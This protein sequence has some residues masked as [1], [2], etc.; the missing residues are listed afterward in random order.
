M[1]GPLQLIVV[2]FDEDKYARDIIL[3]L[4]SLRKAKTILLFDLLYLFKHEDGTIDA[5]EVSDLQEEEQREFGTLVKS[6]LGLSARDVEHIDAEAVAGTLE[7]ADGSFGLSDSELQ[8]LADQIPNGSSAIFVVFEHAWA[9]PLKAA[10]IRTGG[11]VRAQGIIDPDTLKSA[12]NELAAVLAAV[13]KAEQATMEQMAEIMSGAKSQEEEAQARAAEAMAEADVAESEAATTLEEAARM[14]EEAEQVTAEA[15]AREEA[16]REHAAQVA[17]EAEAMEDEAFAEAEAVRRA[18]ER[19]QEK[20]LAEAATVESRAKEIEAAA[21]MRA[22]NA[23]ISA[24]VIEPAE[25]RDALDAVLA[26]DV[27]D[28]SAARKAAQSIAAEM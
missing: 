27:I 9:R 4:K 13:N 26:A 17:A 21:V 24:R 1:L 12:T 15:Q 20:A 19:Q 22:L 14:A 25:T 10:M 2:G 8:Q 23:L 16:A 3:E 5:K 6:L 18:A 11:Y 28:V 7:A